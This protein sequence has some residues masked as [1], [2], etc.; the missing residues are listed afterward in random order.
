[1][2]SERES[3]DLNFA[4]DA[5]QLKTAIKLMQCSAYMVWSSEVWSKRGGG[6]QRCVTMAVRVRGCRSVQYTYWC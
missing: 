6:V 2:K 5:P 1:M 4:I 3:A